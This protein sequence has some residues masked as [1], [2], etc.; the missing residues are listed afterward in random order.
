MVLKKSQERCVKLIVLQILKIMTKICLKVI[1]IDPLRKS[2]IRKRRVE[3]I[4]S[5]INFIV[6]LLTLS[7][8]SC[9]KTQSYNF[10]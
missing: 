9:F 10:I 4:S 6:P 7:G 2:E 8:D 5:M 3:K 1:R